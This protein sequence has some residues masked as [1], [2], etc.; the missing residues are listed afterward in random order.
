VLVPSLFRLPLTAY[1]RLLALPNWV[2]VLSTVFFIR[3]PKASYTN[4]AVA[5]PLRHSDAK[6]H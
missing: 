3:C 5:P 6:L 4:L 1:V 2:M